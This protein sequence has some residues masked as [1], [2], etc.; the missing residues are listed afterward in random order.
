VGVRA[1][2]SVRSREH[3]REK[4]GSTYIVRKLS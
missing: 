1:F 4:K 3:D 2:A